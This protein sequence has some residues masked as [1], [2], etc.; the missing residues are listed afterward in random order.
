MKKIVLLFHVLIGFVLSTPV[1]PQNA[2]QVEPSPRERLLMDSGWRFAFGHPFDAEKDFRHASGYFSYF[3]KTGYGD[4]AAS[5]DFDDR[6]WRGVDLPHDWAVELPFSEKGGYSHGYKAIG[7]DFPETSVGWY[8]KTF[9]V[10]GS[11]LGR[12]ISLEFDGVHRDSRVWVN[13]FYV[14]EEQ[15]GYAGFRY[16]VTDYL[17]YG[18]TNVV[19][20]RVDAT[21]EEG[22]FY[23]G[24]GI[25]RHVWL[26]KT[27]PLHV[28]QYGTFVSSEVSDRSAEITVR[29][30]VANEG[31][32]ETAFDIDQTVWD[33]DGKRIG[34]GTL[35]RLALKPGNTGDYSIVIRLENPRLWS[36]EKPE[37]HRLVTAIRS[38]GSVTDRVE[39]PFGVRAIRFDPKEGFFLN[40]KHVPLKGTNNHQDHAGV[41]TAIP[42]ALQEFRIARLKEMGSNAVRCSHNPP[43]PELLDACD[44]LGMLVIDENRLMGSSAVHLD[45]LGRMILRDRNHPC[46]FA[47]SIGNEEW[48]I[49]GNAAG[50]RIASSMQAFVRR[51][52]PTRAVTYA[53]SGGWGN[54]IS[55]VQEVMG[56]N[57]IFNGNIDKQHADFPWQPAM[58]TEETTSRGTRGVYEDDAP[59]AHMEATDRKTGGTSM[60]TGLKFYAARPFLSG[61]FFWTGFDHRGEPNP[62]GWP[63][64][65]SQCGIV[66]QCGYPKDMFYYLKSWWTDAPVLH[67]LPHWNWKGVKNPEIKVWAY[68]NCDEVELFLNQKS[69]GRKPMPAM[70]HLEWTVLY[71]PGALLARGFMKGKEAV[72]DLVETAGEPA[73]VLLSPDRASINA[74][75]E[76]AAVVTVKVAD[77]RDRTVPAASNEITF[78]VRGPGRIIGVGNGDPSSHEPDRFF[79]RVSQVKIEGLR[80]KAV[81]A[82]AD[83]P[84]T[85]FGY[86]DSK[87]E[88]A[89]DRQGGYNV[90]TEDTLKTAVIRGTFR[91]PAVQ[92][93]TEISLWPKSLCEEQA[94]YVNGR[95][96][97]DRI[98][99]NDPVRRVPLD[100]AFLREGENTV[101]VLGSPLVPRYR[102][103]NLNT[104]PGIVQVVQ[105]APAWR[106]A[107]FNGL[108]QVIVQAS[109]EPGEI[110][111]SAESEGLSR[112]TLKIKAQ[113]CVPRP[114]APAATGADSR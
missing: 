94:V 87:W 79:E 41:G 15:S 54:G 36:I 75:G 18:G 60:E 74:D 69:L 13:G 103:D 56:F 44:R 85:D 95:L 7:R 81:R 109:R 107:V 52:D 43:A 101:A 1:T 24:A 3:A 88:S 72:T 92:E 111:L 106:R 90:K 98:R 113:S 49:E 84:E 10:S 8:R 80:S 100:S 77:S 35:N 67:L 96:V 65:G 5:K 29:T 108:A 57:Y 25:Y 71:A 104:D 4:G 6:A 73:A 30:T 66:D 31:T 70:G 2:N 33:A 17:N 11:D 26:V 9:V 91:L 63:Q 46:V 97:A 62:F 38:G 53:N 83:C 89:L 82:K 27:A 58:G 32:A 61:L 93:G 59:D 64:A 34:A 28:A 76:D 23:E 68:G 50:A 20:V 51:L 37:M 55:T 16:D 102:Y 14:G 48:A 45:L 12:R 42:D 22:W 19:A 112:G 39:T 47:W 110:I 21:M 114:A 99:R 40:G 78:S 86:D 105:P